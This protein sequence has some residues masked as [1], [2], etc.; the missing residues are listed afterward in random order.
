[1]NFQ[2]CKMSPLITQHRFGL[3]SIIAPIIS[4]L[5]WIVMIQGVVPGL[6]NA[7]NGYAGMMIYHII[8]FLDNDNLWSRGSVWSHIYSSP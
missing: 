8:A 2:T 3:M 7:A 6:A 4:V 5:P 1:M